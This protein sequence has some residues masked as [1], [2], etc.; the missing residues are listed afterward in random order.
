MAEYWFHLCPIWWGEVI[1]IVMRAWFLC[2]LRNSCL[3]LMILWWSSN[4]HSMF[5]DDQDRFRFYTNFSTRLNQIAWSS[6]R[7][8]EWSDWLLM[9]MMMTTT[10]TRTMMVMMMNVNNRRKQKKV[11]IPNCSFSYFAFLSFLLMLTDKFPK[12][13][14]VKASQQ[15]FRME[16]I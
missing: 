14:D 12:L 7:S 13:P 1:E 3:N 5:I 11:R 15:Y 6:V 4:D 16:F 9:M 8:W 10:M 2:L